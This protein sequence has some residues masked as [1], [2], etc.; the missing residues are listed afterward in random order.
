MSCNNHIN[1]LVTDDLVED[2]EVIR[3]VKGIMQKRALKRELGGLLNDQAGRAG[4]SATDM[5]MGYMHFVTFCQFFKN[6][7]VAGRYRVM[8]IVL[9]RNK[10]DLHMSHGSGISEITLDE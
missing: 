7:M 3:S 8:D 4:I 1:S 10:E 2:I 9:G 5:E 6:I